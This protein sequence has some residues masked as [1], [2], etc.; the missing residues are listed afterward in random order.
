MNPDQI[1]EQ[2]AQ[3]VQE[4]RNKRTFMLGDEWLYYKFYTGP[5]TADVVLTEIIKPAAEEFLSGNVIDYWFFIRYGDPKNH[6]RVRFHVPNPMNIGVII[7][8]LRERVAPY[9]E[10]SLIWKVQV[11]TYEQ[12]VERYGIDSI[13]L[14]EKLFFHDSKMMVDMLSLIE[15]DEGERIRWLFGLR[16]VDSFL[17]DFGFNMEQ[18]YE[19]VT[20]LRENFG[21]EFGLN[22][23][24]K[25]QLESKFRK[26]RAQINETMDRATDDV[27]EMYPLFKMIEQRSAGFQPIVKNI[28]ELK[29][30][31]RLL[32]EFNDLLWSYSHMM[33]NRL[34]KSRQRLHE[35]VLYDFL[36]RYYKSEI[37][38]RKYSQVNE[39]KK[40]Q[41]K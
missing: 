40:K 22:H 7:T 17:D 26:E 8:A 16:A 24:L 2:E 5:K 21:A 25:E 13:E 27:S 41:K 3:E 32:V 18:K 33:V 28:L 36:H 38:R 30:Q 37:A 34:F 35:L 9:I 20:K 1:K 19:L 39:E 23:G 11:D 6:T 29:E 10:Q 15:G 12:E 31:N 14:A 4:I